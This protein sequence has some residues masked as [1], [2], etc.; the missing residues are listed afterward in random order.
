MTPLRSKYIRDPVIRGRS[1]HTQE[2]YIRYV[3]D[4]ARYYRRSPELISYEEV[5]GWLIP[6][7]SRMPTTSPTAFCM[8]YAA[9]PS[10]RSERPKPRRSGAIAW[11]PFNDEEWDLVAPKICGVRSPLE[12]EHGPTA[13][14]VLHMKRNAVDLHHFAFPKVPTKR[15][16]L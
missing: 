1:K 10:G 13:A 5:T 8:E 6:N 4:L 12:Q 16:D 7:A 15:K 14:V 2:A 3:R 11:N 9:T